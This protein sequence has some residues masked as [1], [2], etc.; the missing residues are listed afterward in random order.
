MVLIVVLLGVMIA[1]I[2]STIVILGLPVMI[3]DLHSDIVTMVWVIMAYLLTLTVLGTQVGRLGDMYGRVRMYNVGFGVFTLGSV[4]CGLSQTGPQ[5]IALRVVQAIGG[6]LIAS[7][8]GAI[9]ADNV[10][11]SERGRAFGLTSIGFN[12]GAIVGILLGGVL[13]TFVNW[14]F[15]FY[16][17]LPIGLFALVASYVV[18]RERSPR[19]PAA[20]DLPGL[21]LLGS[22]LLLFLLGITNVASYG[23]SR[24]T[25]IPILVGS[26]LCAAF[27][28]WE[29][30]TPSPLLD[31]SLFHER[32]FSASILAA[33]FQAL[34]NYA[35]LFL[36]I[37]FLQGVRGLTPFAA[38]L[39]LTP[40]YVVGAAIGPWSGRIS[41]R[42]GARIP[43]SIG[44]MFQI[45][46]ILLYSTLA[47]T[48]SLWVVVVAAVFSGVGS[49]FFF[50]ANTSAV[51]AGAPPGAYG[52]ANGLLRTFANVGMVGSFAVALLAASAAITREEA[53]AIFLGT[54]TLHGPLAGAFIRGVHTALRVA[55]LPVLIALGLSILRGSEARAGGT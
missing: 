3:V 44:L 37:M 18:L 13:I 19:V 35:V 48:T 43:A 51:L 14:R 38:S 50:P 27:V 30:R 47:V 12:V 22:G 25:G 34:G 21:L 2:D 32:V 6:A 26:A 55:T 33:F 7:N 1:A 36:V 4:L 45:V 46:G 28:W 53:F 24:S 8:S 40:G 15:I 20:L 5:L 39:L 29:Q 42:I 41:D 16:I 54:S 17:N 52:V 31:L 9:I 49:G 11:A 10:P 23:L